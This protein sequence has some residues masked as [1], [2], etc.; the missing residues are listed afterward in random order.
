M[1]IRV[2]G[3]PES[4]LAGESLGS[5][6]PVSEFDPAAIPQG[7]AITRKHV[8]IRGESTLDFSG[9]ISFA[10]SSIKRALCRYGRARWRAG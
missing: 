2:E 4:R 7:F 8:G 1:T 9:S 3:L 10:V 5:A 6:H